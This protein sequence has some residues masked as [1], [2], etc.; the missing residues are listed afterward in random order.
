MAESDKL[1][2]EDLRA[3]A[4]ELDT[5]GNREAAVPEPEALEAPPSDETSTPDVHLSQEEAQREY[6]KQHPEEALDKQQAAES[7]DTSDVKLSKD[8]RDKERLDR[9]WKKMQEREAAAKALMDEAIREKAELAKQKRDEIVKSKPPDLMEEKEILENGEK[10]YSVKQY[11]DAAKQ[12]R[13]EGNLDIATQAEAKARE[14][15]TNAF[16]RIWD[17]NLEKLAEEEPDLTDSRKPIS[18]KCNEILNALPVLKTFP[19][20]C[21]YAYRIAMGDNSKSL[22]SE[23]KA[24]NQKL[25]KEVDSLHR[26]TRLTGSG[27]AHYSGGDKKP[28]DMSKTERRQFLRHLAAQADM[29]Y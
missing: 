11:Q 5:S 2:R 4:R 3:L 23:L 8:D 27:P 28:E 17:A 10:G 25:K 16:R 7:S 18:I 1:S 24:E 13:E 26:A 20:G 21:K 14:I 22:I 6:E 15:Y 19:D 29:G 9:N 12:A